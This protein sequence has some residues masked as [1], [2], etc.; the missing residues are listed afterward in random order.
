MTFNIFLRLCI[1]TLLFSVLIIAI[2]YIQIISGHDIH[3]AKQELGIFHESQHHEPKIQPQHEIAL[4]SAEKI[5]FFYSPTSLQNIIPELTQHI[6]DISYS[7]VFAPKISHL[8]IELYR[9]KNDVR[10]KMKHASIQLFWAGYTPND[11][12]VNVFTHELA[13]YI[14]IYFLTKKVFND[15]SEGFYAISWKNTSTIIA[16]QKNK[17]FVSGYAMTNKYEDFA[18]SMTYYIFANEEMRERAKN[19]FSLKKKYEFFERSIFKNNEFKN[20]N[21]SNNNAK[22]YYWDITKISFDIKNFLEYLE[23]TL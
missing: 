22:R 10:G 5:N 17:D 4:H 12:L 9:Q 14:D 15:P 20:T 13:H 16:G 7:Q 18:E 19:S 21:F 11:E 8:D 3:Q 23:K 2:Q 6:S 1:S